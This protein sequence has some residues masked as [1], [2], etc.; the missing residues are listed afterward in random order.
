MNSRETN[1]FDKTDYAENA[2]QQFKELQNKYSVSEVKK[3]FRTAKQKGY[4][5]SRNSF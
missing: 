2:T 5:I 1:E 4:I 3:M